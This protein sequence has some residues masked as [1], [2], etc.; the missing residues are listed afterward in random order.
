M[1]CKEA[2]ILF[3]P[4]IMGD[5]EHGPGF[6][7]QLEAHLLSCQACRE[8]YGIRN[9]TIAFIEQH[10]V[11]FAEAL[12][13][14]EEKKA[15]EKEEIELSWKR[16][17]ARL[18]ELEVQERKEK[19]A[20]FHRLVVR[21]SAIAACL[22]VGISTFL[23]Y[24]IY[25]KPKTALKPS[26]RIE[27]VSD[28]G[29]ILIP[30]DRQI[31]SSDELKTLIIDGRHRMVMNTNTIL[32]VESLRENDNTGCLVKLDTGRIYAHVEHEGDPFIVDTVHGKAVITGTTF[33]VKVTDESTT[34]VVSE[35]TVQ[36]ESE[37]GVVKVAAGQ[38]SEIVGQSAPSIPLSCN[39]AELTA[40]ATGDK[41]KPALAQVESNA[42]PG[43]L[44]L[45]LRKEPIIL[46]ETDYTTWVEQK[47]GLFKQN[48]PWIF[49]LKDALAQEGIKVDYPELL[50]KSGD[51]W[52][53]VCLDVVP[54]RFSVVDFDSLLKTA[55]NYGFGKQWL[56][57]NVPIAKSALERPALSGN[58][59]TG[60]KAFE[61]WF[62]YLDETTELKP[63]TPIYSYHACKYLAETKSL[64][65]FA[66]RDGQYDLKDQ[67]RIDILALLQEEVT[68][69]CKCQ[70]EVLYPK[71]EP[72]PSCCTDKYQEMTDTIVGHITTM[73]VV[74]EMITEHENIK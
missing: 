13:T 28:N 61:R 62:D 6:Y 17:E 51:V 33:D 39:I 30:A 1:D 22:V 58:R 48:F 18:D 49:Q 8:R 42:H 27:L 43:E 2:Q 40:W 26:V 36:F 11:I 35:G 52:Q 57:A 20:K 10:K 3:A 25:L 19:Q 38:T 24:S 67:E 31:V 32:A 55:S 66:V 47:R 41:A 72:K 69:A 70:N 4:H 71:E 16:I 12:R 44:S 29:N 65:W 46:E 45:S 23:T 7:S 37:K 34:L 21:V 64:I 59:F 68:A 50:I 14:P 53:F 56:L 63:P 54:P 15:A 73:K 60:L 9:Q 5:L 74:E